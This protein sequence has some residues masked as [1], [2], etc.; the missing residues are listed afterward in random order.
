MTPIRERKRGLERV[1]DASSD[2]EL[3]FDVSQ[4]QEY[5]D[6][7]DSE[8]V[9]ESLLND[10]DPDS[11]HEQHEVSDND[12][13]A[14][15]FDS[16]QDTNVW[17]DDDMDGLTPREKYL[18]PSDSE[19]DF[20]K[21]KTTIGNVP[22]EWYEDFPHIGYDLEGK[23]VVKPAT[24][25]EL[26]NLLARMDDPDFLATFRDKIQHQDV[27][28]TP[29]ELEI[30]ERLQRQHFP[31]ADM[32]PYPVFEDIFTQDVMATPIS[33]APEPK[34]RFIPSKWEH[35]R[36][37]K[38]VRLI[39]AGVI[40]PNGRK[41]KSVNQE[42]RPRYYDIWG[43][44]KDREE[45]VMHIAAPKMKLP[46]HA[47]SYNPPEE[48]LLDE[49]EQ[50]EWEAMDPEDRP[51]NYMPKKHDA[52]RHVPAY[53]RFINERFERCLDLYLCP[54]AIRKRV[55]D[56]SSLLPQL[57]D[58]K[59]L[60]PFPKEVSIK[61][62]VRDPEFQQQE[63]KL[64]RVRCLSVSP[65]GQ[66][67]VSGYDNGEVRVWEV[68][69]ARCMGVWKLGT[70]D[71]PILS[72][73]WN[74]NKMVS[75]IAVVTGKNVILV[76]PGV[77]NDAVMKS[78]DG[79][80]EYQ[81]VD[82]KKEKVK[83][84]W[85]KPSVSQYEE[86]VRLIL[87]HTFTL[88]QVAWHKKGDYFVSLVPKGGAGSV[89]IHQLSKQQTQSPFSKS[90]GEIQKVLF[91]PTKPFLFVATQRTIRVY[92]LIRQE[93]FK[94]LQSGAKWISSMD[95]HP[96]GDNVIVGTYD[97]KVCWFDMDLS[98]K[99]YKILRNNEF[100]IRQVSFHKRHPLFA[101]CSDDGNVQVFHGMVYNDL[102]QNPTIVPV[103]IVKA[104]RRT[105]GLGALACEFHPYRP[106]IFSSGSDGS[107]NL[108]S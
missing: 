11:D 100:A 49:E 85:S 47:E 5:S 98:S 56:P 106:W 83:V 74:P 71:A 10:A 76:N 105:G 102:M 9:D 20:E 81:A 8:S 69:T 22:V 78:T 61:Y 25:D 4:E 13:E 3:S 50:K 86:G 30:I 58:P 82:N 54:R 60:E 87:S 37:M 7:S 51:R 24:K 92:N 33:G 99:P 91:H 73:A 36:V 45:H 70:A 26:D 79:L 59:E 28:L 68:M 53:D 103:K 108:I 42:E 41:K 39:R 19:D 77:A 89:Q 66:W 31:D 67:M 93:L 55:T 44:D 101:S 64:K 95:I 72:V 80:A 63:D 21:P 38:I 52:L 75:L 12:E 96:Q 14:Y 34:R 90:K 94:K 62:E 2:E 18:A 1:N 27:A 84:T 57:P 32:D 17:T 40:M 23:K 43:Q 48:Y 65:C 88:T 29:E 35:K 15:D 46:E 6:F 16:E 104:Q 107:I 97:K